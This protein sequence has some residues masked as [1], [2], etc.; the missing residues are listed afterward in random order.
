M[1]GRSAAWKRTCL[2][3]WDVCEGS[4]APETAPDGP[5]EHSTQICWLWPMVMGMSTGMIKLLEKRYGK[6]AAGL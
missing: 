3:Q 2:G 4:H 6:V 1:S 5:S